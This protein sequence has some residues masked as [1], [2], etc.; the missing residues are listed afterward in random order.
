VTLAS[1]AY[2]RGSAKVGDKLVTRDFD[3]GTRGF[4]ASDDPGLAVCV[5][6]GTELAFAGD[7]ACLPAGLLGWKTKTINHQTA[8]FRQVNKDKLAAHHDALEFPD[9]RTVLLT[10]LCEGQEARSF[11]CLRG[12][13]A[14]PRQ[15]PRSASPTWAGRARRFKI[16]GLKYPIMKESDIMGA[17]VE[18]EE[19]TKV[20]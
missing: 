3:T 12:Q 4:A 15:M 17:L 2:V 5:L 11:S 10:L 7:V 8:I 13:R 19:R 6:P 9:G 18:A 14:R 1:T 16:E 20:A